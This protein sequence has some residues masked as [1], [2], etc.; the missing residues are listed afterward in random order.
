MQT[1]AQWQHIAERLAE[2]GRSWQHVKLSDRAGRNAHVAESHNDNGQT[3]VA[4]ADSVMPAF[5]AL[6]QSI[7]AAEKEEQ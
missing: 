2:T 3:H 6:E 4:V 7:K 5:L 1:D